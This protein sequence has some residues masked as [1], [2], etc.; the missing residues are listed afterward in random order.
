M[1]N[2]ELDVNL[3]EELQKIEKKDCKHNTDIKN[4]W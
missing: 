4:L 3:K 2:S 1:C